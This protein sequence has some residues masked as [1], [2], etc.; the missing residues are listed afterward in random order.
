VSHATKAAETAPHPG[1]G[2]LDAALASLGIAAE[3]AEGEVAAARNQGLLA[4]PRLTY[5]QLLDLAEARFGGEHVV[6]EFTE[7]HTTLSIRELRGRAERFARALIAAGVTHGES[8]AL[9]SPPAPLWPIAMFGAAMVGVRVCGINTR[10][11][12]EELRHLLGTLRPRLVFAAT[13]FLGIDSLGLIDE[14]LDDLALDPAQRPPVLAAPAGTLDDAIGDFVRGGAEVTETRVGHA[15]AG[16]GHRDVS[17]I[18]FTSGSTGAPKAVLITQSSSVAAAHYGAASMGVSADDVMYSPLP[19]FHIG[20]TIS[21]SLAAMTSGCRM[22]L[23]PRFAAADALAAMA[24]G[25]PTAFQGHGALWRM[26]RDEHRARPVD[27]GRLRKGWS[28]GDYEFLVSLQEELGVTELINMYGSSESGT[29]SCTLP[30][31]P[32]ELRLGALGRPTPGT[33]VSL[34][35]PSSGA[36]VGSGDVG[37]LWLRGVM[38]MA[39]YLTDADD[40]GTA[41][42]DW[43]ATGDLVHRDAEGVLHYDGRADDR[44]K[45]G[46]ENVSIA[47]VESFIAADPRIDEV[48]V[49]GVPDARLGDVP[50]AVVR[51]RSAEVTEDAII[52]RCRQN[53]AGF[54]VPRYVRLVDSIPT[55]DTGKVDRRRVR[56]ELLEALEARG[57]RL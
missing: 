16:V 35:D 38:S 7:P 50:A 51:A 46:G 53:I 20:G 24:T 45:P 22:V 14:A 5:A 12:R 42:V 34:R 33:E 21:T 10:Y 23:P 11:R 37:E 4:L 9:W 41:P 36:E 26:L 3:Y 6:F 1:Q 19:F 15:S 47:E 17:L 25:V 40:H 55:L 44:L 27:T 54:K 49:V 39:G 13:G 43:I 29:I 48:V 28:S 57:V 18:Q 30:R 2:Q 56:A 31:D 8:I 32:V 52:L